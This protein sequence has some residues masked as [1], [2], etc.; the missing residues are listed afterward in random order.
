[1][2]V[3]GGDGGCLGSSAQFPASVVAFADDTDAMSGV[4][5][6]APEEEYAR[7]AGEMKRALAV[8]QN[9]AS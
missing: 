9:R 6:G 4:E 2:V 5:S 3:G 1:M 7:L 8:F